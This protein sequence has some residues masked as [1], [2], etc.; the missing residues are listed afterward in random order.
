VTTCLVAQI[1]ADSLLERAE[2][3]RT[4]RVEELSIMFISVATLKWFGEGPAYW[5]D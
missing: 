4:V 1:G 3:P 2:E 5:I